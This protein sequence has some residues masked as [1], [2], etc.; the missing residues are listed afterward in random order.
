MIWTSI[1][2]AR[3]RSCTDHS[4]IPL[5]PRSRHRLRVPSFTHRRI[6]SP[7]LRSPSLPMLC[8]GF[9]H[10]VVPSHTAHPSCYSPHG[11]LFQQTAG[12]SSLCHH[13]ENLFQ[14]VHVHPRGR[15][16]IHHLRQWPSLLPLPT[17]VSRSNRHRL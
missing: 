1:L 15:L 10:Q 13:L 5:Q 4:N 6:S 16:R 8:Q 17:L 14:S 12:W 2:T 7:T 11:H 3:S 9:R